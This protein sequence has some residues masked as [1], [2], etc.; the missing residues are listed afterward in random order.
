[1]EVEDRL[2]TVEQAAEYYHV[3]PR[4]VRVW[5]RD[6]KLTALKID[7][8]SRKSPVRLRESEVKALFQP[9]PAAEAVGQA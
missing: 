3:H 1:M 5:M 7:P 6:G 8:T 4:T 9:R 2:M